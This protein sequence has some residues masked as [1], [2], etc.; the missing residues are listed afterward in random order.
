MWGSVI[1]WPVLNKSGKIGV[2]PDNRVPWWADSPSSDGSMDQGFP[3]P[4][5][6]SRPPSEPRVP[7]SLRSEPYDWFRRDEMGEEVPSG[8]DD[9]GLTRADSQPSSAPTIDPWGSVEPEPTS[10]SPWGSTEPTRSSFDPW[11]SVESEP[12]PSPIGPRG[13]TEPAPRSIDPWGSVEPTP[14]PID[15]RGSVEPEPT[16]R[17]IDSWGSVEPEPTPVAKPHDPWSSVS[18]DDPWAQLRTDDLAIDSS[19]SSWD[20]VPAAANSSRAT[21]PAAVNSSRATV[22]PNDSMVID[23]GY[24]DATD[25]DDDYDYDEDDSIPPRAFVEGEEA[26]VASSRSKARRGRGPKKGFRIALISVLSVVLIAGGALTYVWLDLGGRFNNET[27]KDIMGTSR[28]PSAGSTTNVK[29]PGDPYAGRAVNILVLGTDSRDGA[30]AGVAGNN[31]GGARSDTTLI[32]HVSADRTRIDVISIPRDTWIT[33][34]NCLDMDGDVIPEAGWAHMGFNA[35]FAYGV[36]SG[37]S[38]ATGAACAMRAVEQ[39][40]N[41]RMDAYVIVDFSGFVEVVDAV[42]GVDIQL[43]CPINAPKAHGLKLPKG[44]VHINGQTAV[45]LA[46]ART[47]QG[48]GDGSD[49]H[50]I[51][52]QQAL[53]SAIISKVYDMNYVKD[54]PKLYKLVAA[55]IASVT[56]DIGENLAQ[57][58][59]FAYSLKDLSTSKLTFEMIPVMS[60]GNGVNV[61]IA[62]WAAEPYWAALRADKPMPGAE[63]DTPAEPSNTPT[64]GVTPQVTPGQPSETPKSSGP[65]V[66]QRESDCW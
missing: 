14:S 46:R 40:S 31:V 47:G 52:R 62:Q 64:P 9:L 61:Q 45:N 59:G 1:S 54:F 39:M 23:D 55:V 60:A 18:A 34:P 16:P 49:L 2:M 35:A 44:V 53:F 48:L 29:Y 8:R 12:T 20:P 51:H 26:K 50:R 38:L 6:A 15:S 43:L 5:T 42:G 32:V 11:G 33:I 3:P 25:D 13:S 30:N 22:T 19:V 56:T 10:S 4:E 63:V 41:L 65:V 28:P 36:Y 21:V 58:A 27:V 37:G 7:G 66:I 17:S 57:I 24:D